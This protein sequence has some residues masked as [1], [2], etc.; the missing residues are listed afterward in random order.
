MYELSTVRNASHLLPTGGS[1]VRNLADEIELLR[2]ELEQRDK[3]IDD[4]VKQLSEDF[5]GY[6]EINDRRWCMA[7]LVEAKASGMMNQKIHNDLWPVAT[8]QDGANACDQTDG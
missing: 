4:R 7:Q 1:L 3:V 6:H 8:C 2:K 5:E